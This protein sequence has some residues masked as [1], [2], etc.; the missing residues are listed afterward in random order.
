MQHTFKR[1]DQES[2][3]SKDKS[4]TVR[5]KGRE[6]SEPSL[7]QAGQGCLGTGYTEFWDQREGDCLAGGSQPRGDCRLLCLLTSG[8]L[9]SAAPDREPGKGIF[10]KTQV[11]CIWGSGVVTRPPDLRSQL[12]LAT[13]AYHPVPGCSEA[14]SALPCSGRDLDTGWQAWSGLLPAAPGPSGA[15]A[16]AGEC[17]TGRGA[18]PQTSVG[19]RNQSW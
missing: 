10:Q 12:P 1:G 9:T 14:H 6:L 17:P 19:L 2:E 4:Q 18:S 13:S 5:R 11:V 16:S 3:Q 7:P 15:Q 8:A